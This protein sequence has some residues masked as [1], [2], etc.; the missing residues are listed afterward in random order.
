M[1]NIRTATFLITQSRIDAKTRNTIA[2]KPPNRRCGSRCIPPEWDCRLKGEGGDGHL[3]AAGRGSDPLAALASTQ[4]GLGRLRKG[5]T[6]G[7][8]SELEGGRKAVIR[9][10]VKASPQ[11][12]KKKKELQAALVQGSIGI[13]VALAVLGGGVRA[14]GI[15]SNIRSYREGIGKNIDDSVSNALHSVLDLH[16][17]RARTKTE[18]RNAVAELVRRRNGVGAV[19][20]RNYGLPDT[21]DILKTS[22]LDYSPFSAVGQRVKNVSPSAYTDFGEW[23][24]A[25]YKA[26]WSTPRLKEQQIYRVGDGYQFATLSGEDFLRTHYKVTG[27]AEVSGVK[28]VQQIADQLDAEHK[29]LT[30]YA[31]DRGFNLGKLEDRHSLANTL[32]DAQQLTPAAREQARSQLLGTLHPNF[33]A[34][35]TAR[36]IYGKTIS[37]Y[38]TFYESIINSLPKVY[39]PTGLRKSV[40]LDQYPVMQNAMQGHAEFFATRLYPTAGRQAV[41]GPYSADLVNQH[42]FQTNGF[43]ASVNTIWSAPSLT[44]QKAASEHA[45][46]PIKDPSE[47]LT[48]LRGTGAFEGLQIRPPN[49][50]NTRTGRAIPPIPPM[51]RPRRA[52]ESFKFTNVEEQQSYLDVLKAL[53]DRTLP[54][55]K[56]LYK[57]QK[58]AEAAARVVIQRRRMEA[59]KPPERGDAYFQAFAATIRQDKRCGKSGIPDNRNCSKKTLAAQAASGGG[60]QSAAIPKD[61]DNTLRNVAIGAGAVAA[62]AV[63][64]ALGVKSQQVFAY[65]R[66]V[67]RSA[68]DAEA[69]AKDM[70]REF[71]EKAAKRL[72]KDVKDVT[73]FEASTYNFKDKGYDTGFSGMDNT[74][75]FYGQTQNSKGAVVMLSYADDGTFTKRGQGS[76][77]MAEGGA[78]REIWGEHDIL[79]FANKISQPIKQGADDLDMK[80][81][82]ARIGMLPKVAQK[83]VTMGIEMKNAFK[84][85]DY[86]RGNIETRGFNPDAVRAAAFVAAQRRLTGKPVHMLAYSNGGNVASETLAI[87][88]EMGY[89]DVKVVNVAGPTFG[90]FNHTDENMRTWVSKGDVFY[91]TMGKRAFASSPVRML[92]NNNIPHGLS[93]KIDPNN[94]EFGA[95]W[96]KYFKAGDSY[97]LDKQLQKEAHSYLTV[98]RARSKELTNEMVWRIASDK[99]IEGDLQVLFGNKSRDVKSRY[100]KALSTNKQQALLQLRS[101]IED[102]MIDVWYGGY[103]PNKV[104]R[105]SKSLRAE[106]QQNATGAKTVPPEPATSS[107]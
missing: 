24:K 88:A 73:P 81:R 101:E 10:A 64:L 35:G 72:G 39:G 105:S 53:M 13:G 95:N 43:P 106:V 65:R 76:H 49:E 15:L 23:H 89:R 99:P 85:M 7:N 41:K 12:L 31:K 14:H 100:I 77:L 86:L 16:P 30:N 60:G 32:L 9:G 2:C 102:R 11:D 4:R 80:T 68:I 96:R 3:K 28:L 55:G 22:P 25:S 18:A 74:P 40:P 63:G 21:S 84:Q 34:I 67:S 50:L 104:K 17:A 27:G 91:A 37:S 87:L 29:T 90:V 26:M 97:L 93:E 70:V 78:F 82:K 92:Q 54:N 6:T 66:N 38:D 107:N 83:P 71:N 58:S 61:K 69:M 94:P 98:D 52:R 48:I 103:D 42:Y 51:N 1:T 20:G 59:R 79:P 57:N 56:P 5:I 46:R 44:I 19:A 36:T 62:T 45:G 8:F 47:A 75:A 33:R